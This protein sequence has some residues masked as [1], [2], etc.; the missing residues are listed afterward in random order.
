LKIKH[1]SHYQKALD[2]NPDDADYHHNLGALLAG[3]GRHDEA[4][5]H[6]KKAVEIRP[7]YDAARRSLEAARSKR[8]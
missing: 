5:A 2:S 4:I 8:K 1:R 3:C 6:F 7:D